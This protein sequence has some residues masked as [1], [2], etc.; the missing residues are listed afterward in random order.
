MLLNLSQDVP[1]LVA[2]R[3]MLNRW[4]NVPN[5]YTWSWGDRT[6]H[7]SSRGVGHIATSKVPSLYKPVKAPLS[8]GA[9]R[10]SNAC[11]LHL[12]VGLPWIHSRSQR[13]DWD[14]QTRKVLLHIAI[15]L[16]S[17]GAA[18]FGERGTECANKR[19]RLPTYLYRSNSYTLIF[20]S[21]CEVRKFL[22]VSE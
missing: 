5:G 13:L 3:W 19:P 22:H 16:L 8:C 6:D 1:G 21:L 10:R 7:C 14:N 2:E 18:Q 20:T 17:N 15:L 9:V 4:L 12:V 11:N